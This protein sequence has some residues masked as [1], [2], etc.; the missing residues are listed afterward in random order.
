MGGWAPVFDGHNQ[1]ASGQVSGIADVG[2]TV[3]ADEMKTEQIRTPSGLHNVKTE[4]PNGNGQPSTIKL[5]QNMSSGGSNPMST[6]WFS[7]H[8]LPRTIRSLD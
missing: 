1:I 4:A 8:D 7:D 3:G 6:I 5:N 2:V